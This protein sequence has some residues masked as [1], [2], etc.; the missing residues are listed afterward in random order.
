MSTAAP[1]APDRT[2]DYPPSDLQPPRRGRLFAWVARK[3]KTAFWVTAITALILGAMIGGSGGT[4]Q[5]KLDAATAR[6][7]VAEGKASKLE[8]QLAARAGRAQRAEGANAQLKDKITTLSAKGEVPSLTGMDYPDARDDQTVSTYHWR[9]R[10]RTVISGR[11][12]GTV[13]AQT[14][15]EAPTLKAG[16]SIT[17]TVARKAPPKP[18]QWVT[19]KT[20]QGASSTKTPEFS[21]PSGAK[22]RLTSPRPAG[23]VCA[24]ATRSGARAPAADAAAAPP[25]RNARADPGR[26]RSR[27][28]CAGTARRAVLT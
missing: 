11:E 28:R 5:S 4:D 1:P 25:R 13:L 9:V 6:A 3:P 18:K 21:I 15:R 2:P 19:T 10:S 26:G 8:S 22:A 14:P 27:T 16:R 24:S 20:F 23:G 17:L 12:P 7:G